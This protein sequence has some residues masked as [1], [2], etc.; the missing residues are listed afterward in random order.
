[1]IKCPKCQ[2]SHILQWDELNWCLSC[3]FRWTII[4]GTEEDWEF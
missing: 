2:L 4:E 1:M 3:G